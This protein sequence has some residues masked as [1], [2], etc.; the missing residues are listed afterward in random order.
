MGVREAVEQAIF[1]AVGAA[2]LTRERA[3]AIVDDLVR[4]GQL[5]EEEGRLTVDH[6]M[7][8]ARQAGGGSAANGSSCAVLRAAIAA[9]V[10]YLDVCDDTAYSQRAKQ[11]HGSAEAAGV[12]AITTAGIYPGISNV[13]A[14]HMIALGR[15]EYAP[16]GSYAEQPVEGGAEPTRLLY[17]YFTAG[18]PGRS[19]EGVGRGASGTLFD[20]SLASC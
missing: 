5:G 12:P 6:L 3:E 15:R 2:A 1:V 8:R 14:A 19:G 17:S 20:P 16:D 18:G 9:G 7:E 11:L 10:P 13:M 4:R